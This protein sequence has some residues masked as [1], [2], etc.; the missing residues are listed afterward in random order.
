MTDGKKTSD[1]DIS[2]MEAQNEGQ[3]RKGSSDD[4]PLPQKRS[5]KAEPE[6]KEADAGIRKGG[7]SASRD[8]L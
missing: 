6:A 1:D 7:A 8:D 3:G 4:G 5:A 2:P